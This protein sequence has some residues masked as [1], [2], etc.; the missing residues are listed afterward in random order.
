[1]D[2]KIY[3][4]HERGAMCLHDA[5][6]SVRRV[7]I[8]RS[9]L[10]CVSTLTCASAAAGTPYQPSGMNLTYGNVSHGQSLYSATNNPAAAA[11]ELAR[12][13]GTAPSGMAIAGA[14][15]IAYGNVQDLFDFYDRISAPYEPSEPGDGGSATLPEDGINLGDILDNLD[16]EYSAAL[17]AIAAEVATQAALLAV[18]AA[19]GYGKA[20]YSAD[21]PVVLGKEY[22]GG[23]WTFGV[24]WSG[25]A[26][27]HGYSIPLNFD[28]ADAI[29]AISDW[30]A[31]DPAER[32]IQ[33]PVGVDLILDRNPVTG[34]VG[35][36]FRNDSSLITKSA[37][38]TEVNLGYGWDVWKGDSGQL[39]LGATARMY[40]M[41]LSRLAVRFGDLTDSQELFDS[42]RNADYNT[43]Q[44]LSLDF[45]AL[46]VGRN[47]QLG[48]QWTNL[49]EPEF[50]FPAVDLSNYVDQGIIDYLTSDRVY[51][52]NRQ[53]KLEASIF[54]DDRRK[55][56]NLGIDAD[57][58]TDPL[59]DEY[60]W[61]TVSAGIKMNNWWLPSARIGYRKNL[62]GTELD[63]LSL[64]VTAF[65]YLDID[66]ASALN[67]VSIDGTK[68][69]QGLMG[70][71]GF[72]IQF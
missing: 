58:V 68:L 16:P 42:I 54:S 18:I 34:D 66:I 15:G 12:A 65:K 62:S 7:A 63:Y 33:L 11:A 51:T 6:R 36:R 49:N 61:L 10:A 37:R 40:S 3:R 44:R 52:M 31:I 48:A 53:L 71:I 56:A 13:G 41:Q 69:P 72:Q 5:P 21:L 64:G 8:H 32:P 57:P 55:S 45:G 19:E 29:Q 24:H 60:Q 30:L 27:A 46:W 70:S 50:V 14:A 59:G 2:A 35:L 9:I 43:D 4:T 22:L 38:T 23:A 47:Y 25:A 26:K 28:P 17:D 67:T 20:W 1:M 39:F